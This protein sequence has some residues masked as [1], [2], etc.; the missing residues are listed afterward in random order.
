MSNMQLVFTNQGTVG[1]YTF[2]DNPSSYSHDEIPANEESERTT[3]AKLSKY[4]N[5][6]YHIFSLSFD[7]IG[8]AQYAQLGTIYRTRTPLTFYPHDVVRG[9]A[10]SFSVQWTGNFS[11]KLIAGFFDSGYILDMILEST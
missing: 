6:L 9:T 3:S 2:T 8:T 1:T 7:N 5:G 4:N 10:E 11:P